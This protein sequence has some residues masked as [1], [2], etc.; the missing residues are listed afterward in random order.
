MGRESATMPAS[1]GTTDPRP[2][3]VV[4]KDGCQIYLP[5]YD[6][7]FVQRLKRLIPPRCRVFHQLPTPSYTVVAPWHT[8]AVALAGEWWPDFT[9]QYTDEPYTFPGDDRHLALAARRRGG[10][11]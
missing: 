11:R 3:A 4:Y 7:A 2:C 1:A 9:R 10:R 8:K 5:Q 6:Q